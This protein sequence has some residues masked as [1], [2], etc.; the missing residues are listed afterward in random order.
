[1]NQFGKLAEKIGI[2][3][4]KGGKVIVGQIRLDGEMSRQ[5]F[6]N[7]KAL[8]NNVK[9][10]WVDGVL[11]KSLHEQIPI[12]LGLENHPNAVASPWNMDIINPDKSC[13]P[14]PAGTPVI[15]VFNK[16]GE[17][18]TLLILGEPGSGKTITLLQLARDLIARADQEIDRRIP[19]VLNLSSWAAKKQ[20]IAKWI[21]E[22]L[23]STFQ[24]NRKIG[25]LWVE[26]QELLL[27]LDGLDEI[28]DLE[29]R[30]ACVTALNAFQQE[31]AT[32]MVVCCRVRD[33]EELGDR[34][35][36]QSDLVLQPLTNDQIQFYLDRLQSNLTV[37][38]TLLIEDVMLQDLAQSP[39]LLNIMVIA[40]QGI[41]FADV[42]V[43][44]IASNRKKQLFDDYINRIFQNSRS[45]AYHPNL[46][47]QEKYRYSRRVVIFRLVWMAKKM[48][49]HSQIVFLCEKM[50]FSWLNKEEIIFYQNEF[51]V[52]GMLVGVLI[53]KFILSLFSMIFNIEA[54]EIIGLLIS[55]FIGGYAG[56][57]FSVEVFSEIKPIESVK[58]LFWEF[59]EVFLRS[60]RIAVSIMLPVGLFMGLVRSIDMISHYGLLR[61]LFSEIPLGLAFGLVLGLIFGVIGG[62]IFGLV[63]GLIGSEVEEKIYPNQGIKKSALNSLIFGLI[64]GMIFGLLGLFYG[65]IDGL[66]GQIDWFINCGLL[67]GLLGGLIGALYFG[68]WACIQHLVL[69]LILYSTGRV[70]WNYS[71]FLDW[72]SDK[73]FLQKVGGGYIFI[74]RSLMEHFAEMESSQ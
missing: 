56:Y 1:M 45:K 32:G 13:Q 67:G 48:V 26:K 16:L 36:L 27:L 61:A 62:I 42:P 6:R 41:E 44:T 11:E 35:K 47:S 49:Q 51:I 64:Y 2:L 39:L 3:V 29:K 69:R 18:G 24:I 33:Y 40:Y 38:K 57:Q 12:V 37:L 28:R 4:Q 60:L 55:G 30:N 72:A 50:Q 9:T 43:S 20:T 46:L 8:L 53:N 25:Q 74:H 22:E 17:G 34:L 15:E 73:L 71:K 66:Q 31:Q 23:N 7:R 21:V 19:V 10:A 63:Y 68:G 70:P 52:I 65:L 59:K 5:E 14:L 54:N 58:W